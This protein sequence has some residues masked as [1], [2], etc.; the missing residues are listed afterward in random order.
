MLDFLPSGQVK[1]LCIGLQEHLP[2]Q[3][4]QSF[5]NG[6][7]F[8]CFRIEKQ[9]DVLESYIDPF[10]LDV[11]TPHLN[12]NLNHLVQRTSVSSKGEN[13]DGSK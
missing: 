2:T 7:F 12:S 3:R 5:M 6:M 4:E 13:V 1:F 11:F 9:I 10:D 8:L